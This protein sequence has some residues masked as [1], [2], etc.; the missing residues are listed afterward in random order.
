MT[1]AI[2]VLLLACLL[3]PTTVRAADD[4]G[5]AAEVLRTMSTTPDY[6]GLRMLY[7][8]RRTQAGD[9]WVQ[10]A[11][12]RRLAGALDRLR[13]EALSV[14]TIAPESPVGQRAVTLTHKGRVVRLELVSMREEAVQRH[15]DVSVITNFI[16]VRAHEDRLFPAPLRAD[17][18][19]AVTRGIAAAQAGDFPVALKALGDARL[20]APYAP[21]VFFNLG[22][23]ESKMP[24]RE[25]RAIAWFGA[26]LTADPYWPPAKKEAVLQQMSALMERDQENLVKWLQLV[27]N[28]TPKILGAGRSTWIGFYRLVNV[29]TAAGDIRGAQRTAGLI[30]RS[31]LTRSLSYAAIL[32]AQLRSGDT[33]G[34]Q[35]TIKLITDKETLD[36]A[37]GYLANPGTV[38]EP[39]P[40]TRDRP[41]PPPYGSSLPDWVRILDQAGGD[42][43]CRLTHPIFLDTSAY[44]NSTLASGLRTPVGNY[45]ILDNISKIKIEVRKCIRA[46]QAELTKL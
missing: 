44:M 7:E 41:P 2:Q 38:P 22:V 13:S 40:L 42:P 45:D 27:Q 34:A 28:D 30:P 26:Y 9:A 12:G 31:E 18:Q 10:S 16:L 46:M 4:S 21:E 43:P 20:M 3:L 23:A 19:D 5:L 6:Q 24:G 33:A 8:K 25:L 36:L 14:T 37:R 35:K 11:Y 32:R 15:N 1:W 29:Q 39:E 17:A